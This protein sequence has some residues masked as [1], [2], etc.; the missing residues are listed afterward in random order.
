VTEPRV[1]SSRLLAFKILGDITTKD[2]YANLALLKHLQ[3]SQLPDKDAAFVTELINGLSRAM[4]TIDLIIEVA[5]KRSL[6]SLQPAVVNILRLGAYQVL[7]MRVPPHAMSVMVNLAGHRLGQR[8]RGLVNAILRQV[9]TKTWQSWLE[10]ITVDVD[11]LSDIALRLCH[12]RWIVQSY[13]AVLP[14]SEVETALEANNQPPTP[15][16]AVRPGLIEA[17]DLASSCG[18]QLTAFS[19]WG[20]SLKG[21][22][23]QVPAVVSGQAG[24]QDEGSQLVVL[25][26]SRAVKSLPGPWLDLC[27]GPGGK[28]ALLRGLANDRFLLAADSHQQR[29]R[30]VATSLKAFPQDQHQIIVCDGQNPAWRNLTFS[31]VLVDVPCSG[32]GALRRRADARWRH[33]E[34]DLAGL[35]D[36]QVKL[37]DSALKAVCPGGIVAY[38]TCSP[39]KR[40]TAE[41]VNQ[42]AS[43]HKASLLS[44]P[45]FLAEVPDCVAATDPHFVQL[46]PHR[47]NTDAMFLSLI[48]SA[49]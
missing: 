13:Q 46:W 35:V 49:S 43:R 15:V 7:R 31:L 30:L 9:A 18:G 25:A 14:E 10:T 47:H 11:P 39:D 3:A 4:G 48:E 37:L 26:I 5:A 38:V 16:L 20:V 28:S 22:P 2:A 33:Q 1:D 36:L 40:E 17:A 19:P 34:A 12:P 27:A 41:V 45:S 29:A 44:A 24:V 42:V 21:Y 23:G 8:V 6:S 32:L